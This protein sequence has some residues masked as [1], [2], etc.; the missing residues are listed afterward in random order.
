MADETTRARQK[1]VAVLRAERAL[2]KK[3]EDI[4]WTHDVLVPAVDEQKVLMAAGAEIPTYEL[5]EEN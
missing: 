4:D 3:L 5:V 1:L 2:K